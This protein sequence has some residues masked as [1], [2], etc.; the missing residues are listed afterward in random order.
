MDIKFS[1]PKLA[2]IADDV[3]LHI[4]E[5]NPEVTAHEIEFFAQQLV[6]EV[7]NTIT[8]AGMKASNDIS[9]GDVDTLVNAVKTAFNISL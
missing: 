1:N 7:I 6:I 5:H 3:G 4:A 2:E 9:S 8:A